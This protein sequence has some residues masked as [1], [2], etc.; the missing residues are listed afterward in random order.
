MQ[1]DTLTPDR[2][3]EADPLHAQ[4]DGPD[5]RKKLEHQIQQLRADLAEQMMT[6]FDIRDAQM[7]ELIQ[8]RDHFRAECDTLRTQL[9][10]TTPQSTIAAPITEQKRSAKLP[11]PDPLSDG[12]NPTYENWK[13]QIK[14]KLTVNADHYPTEESKMA[15]V[16]GRTTGEAQGH[17]EPRYD[18]DAT[19]PFVTA[20]EMINHLAAI[21]MDPYKKE[22]AR[23]EF[24]RLTMK[25]SQP[26]TEFHT[27]FLRLAGIA[28]IPQEDH[29]HELYDKITIDLQKAV[30]PTMATLQTHKALADQCLLL[31][32]GLKRIRERSDRLRKP[33]KQTSTITPTASP[34]NPVTGRSRPTYDNPARQTLSREGK[35]FICQQPGHLM[36]DCPMRGGKDNGGIKALENV[37]MNQNTDNEQGKGQL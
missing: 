9:R 6:E 18:D 27:R 23:F 16:F 13:I 11:D 20:Q 7:E 32:Q 21:Y 14:G 35:C 4:L 15:Y 37:E 26:F 1:T 3:T 25:P 28:E 17:L 29:R 22:N 30:L 24:R 36:R 33:I 8:E 19:N 31:D 5:F 12:K 10:E 2:E 34:P